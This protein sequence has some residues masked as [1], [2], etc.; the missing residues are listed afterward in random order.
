MASKKFGEE[1]KRL[2]NAKGYTQQQ[3][4]DMLGLTSRST[5]GSWEAGKSEPDA[6]TFLR[7]CSLYGVED[8]YKTFGEDV[9]KDADP[10]LERLRAK[11]EVSGKS[12]DEIAAGAGL[13]KQ[14]LEDILNDTINAK[15]VDVEAVMEVLGG[16]VDDLIE[17]SWEGLPEH[18]LEVARA[19]A[20]LEE[21]MQNAFRRALN[22]PEIKYTDDNKKSRS[23]AM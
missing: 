22:L 12:L 17:S 1:L 8:M 11:V 6:Y 18:A 10:W 4:A 14:T 5:L 19:Y 23:R 2:R 20:Q 9:K 16:T 13:D 15:A 21:K 3:A 7:L